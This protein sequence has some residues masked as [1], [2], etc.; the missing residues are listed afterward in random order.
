MN[1]AMTRNLPL[2]LAVAI[3]LGC[4]QS[5]APAAVSGTWTHD[6]AIPGMGFQMTLDTQDSVVTGSGTWAGEAC[7]SG[8]VT[9]TGVVT[10]GILELDITSTTSAG[11]PMGPFISHFEGSA[12]PPTFDRLAGTLTTNGQSVPY[13]YRRVQ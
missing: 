8:V 13:V 9:V 3:S 5:T 2:T 1:D 11:V 7:C 12:L 4:S 6:Y 10:R